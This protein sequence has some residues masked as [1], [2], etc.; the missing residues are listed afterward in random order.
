MG[1][2]SIHTKRVQEI[3]IGE[4][5]KRKETKGNK[6]RRLGTRCDVGERDESAE[7]GKKDVE[8]CKGYLKNQ[9]R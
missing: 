2:Q 1:I 5:R 7:D 4:R 6:K 9:E 3:I 8:L